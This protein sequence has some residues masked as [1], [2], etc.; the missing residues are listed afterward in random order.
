MFASVR[1]GLTLIILLVVAPISN[2]E[3]IVWLSDSATFGDL[4]ITTAAQPGT[5]GS[6]DIWIKT[7]QIYRLTN[8]SLDLMTV[9]DAIDLT[10]ADI[11]IG[12]N[13]FGL[14]GKP[15]VEDNGST[16]RDIWGDVV[17]HFG[18][19]IGQGIPVDNEALGAYKFATIDYR[20]RGP[21]TS[22]L[23]LK[24]GEFRFGWGISG[25][26]RLHIGIDDPVTDGYIAG[27]TD[28]IFDGRI[29]VVPEPVSLLLLLLGRFLSQSARISRVV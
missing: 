21:G 17:I 25:A 26:D 1:N 16:I 10:G 27:A 15:V 14:Q 12:L 20:V 22:N 6:F 24:V 5:T 28:V 3:T 9:G 2:G 23:Q 4:D 13:R 11:V 7:E 19:G 8:A 29:Q 18:T